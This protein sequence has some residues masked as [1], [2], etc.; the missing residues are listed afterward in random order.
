MRNEKLRHA[1]IARHKKRRKKR[2][3]ITQVENYF[4]KKF[5]RKSFAIAGSR[6]GARKYRQK[7]KLI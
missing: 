4:Y 1:K 7:Y 5:R 3:L 2:S 6:H